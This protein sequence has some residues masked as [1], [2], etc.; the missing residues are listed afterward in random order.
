[1]PRFRDIYTPKATF[2]YLTPYSSQNLGCS[3]WYILDL[4][5]CW[6]RTPRA[7]K[8]WN[9]SRRIQT[10]VITIP[11]RHWLCVTVMELSSWLFWP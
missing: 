8:P 6:E 10:C 1:M 2:P 9:Y 7:N 5:V 4:G 3:L 11:Q